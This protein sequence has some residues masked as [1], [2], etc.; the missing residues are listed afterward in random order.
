MSKKYTPVFLKDGDKAPGDKTLV[1]TSRPAK[2]APKMTPTTLA[3][4]TSST[5]GSFSSKFNDKMKSDADPS[6]PK[7]VNFS[8][9]DDF[10]SLGGNSLGGNTLSGN[11]LG[12]PINPNKNFADMAKSWAKKKEKE[13]RDKHKKASRELKKKN[14][15]NSIKVIPFSMRRQ[16]YIE[17]EDD[18]NPTYDDESSIGDNDCDLSSYDEQPSTEEDDEFNEF[19]QDTV[20]SGRRQNDLY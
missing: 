8:S 5:S 7:P 17:E 18:Y 15:L 9:L 16:E 20:A 6:K 3:N 14:D 4:I 12:S 11:S 10:P 19:N 13:E 2:E 1:N